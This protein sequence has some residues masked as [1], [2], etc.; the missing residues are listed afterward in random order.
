MHQRARPTFKPWSFAFKESSLVAARCFANMV[1][2]SASESDADVFHDS[3]AVSL[4]II[5]AEQRACN[6]DAQKL[7]ARNSVKPLTRSE[8]KQARYLKGEVSGKNSP[9]LNLQDARRHHEAEN[10]RPT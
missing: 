2:S 10:L 1:E 8:G 4:W 9:G 5:P 3:S 7:F 6:Q